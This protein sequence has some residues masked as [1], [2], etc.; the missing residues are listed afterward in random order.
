MKYIITD[1]KYTPMAY[2]VGLINSHKYQNVIQHI[3]TLKKTP[4]I[5]I[6]P[7]KCII[8]KEPATIT[9]FD[10]NEKDIELEVESIN[11]IMLT[12]E[13][14][15]TLPYEFVRR[16]IDISDIEEEKPKAVYEITR[17]IKL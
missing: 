15:N 16:V 17:K 6:K 4:G 5:D 10:V 13:I 2:I 12:I 1:V 9:R 3:F 7:G 11:P 8:N 14:S